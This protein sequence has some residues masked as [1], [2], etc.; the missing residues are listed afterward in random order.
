[1][2]SGARALPPSGEAHCD[3]LVVGSGA[4]GLACAVTAAHGGAKVIVAERESFIGGT[5]AW[6]GGWLYVPGYRPALAGD[7]REEIVEYLSHLAG[8]FFNRVRIEA[9]LDANQEMVEFFEGSTSVQFVHPDSAPDYHME[10]PGA[11]AGGRCIYARPVDAR[12]LGADRLRLSSY[13]REITVL[14]VMPQIGPDLQQ[15]LHANR[16]LRSFLYVAARL[17]RNWVER[18]RYR[19]GLDLSNGNALI[20]RLLMSTAH[21]GVQV[22][23]SARVDQLTLSNGV[24]DGALLKTVHG[25]VRVRATQGVVLACGG[26]SHNSELR[27]RLFAH[28]SGG[29]DHH[30]PVSPSH[31]GEALRLSAE[32]GGALDSNVSQ[33]AAW[34]P[35]T[36][37]RG[38]GRTRVFPHLRGVGLPGIIAVTRH[39]QRFTNE[40]D[41]YHDF[42]QAM[43][44]ANADEVDVHAFLVCDRTTMHR[45]GIG[46][47]KPW[48]LPRVGYRRSGY[49]K[50]GR[51]LD[52][53][54]K[55]AGIDPAPL[56]ETIEQFNIYARVGQDPVFERGKSEFNWFKGDLEHRPNPSLAP[57]ERGPFYAVKVRLGDL[58]T[59][60]GLAVDAHSQVLKNS[61]EV[62]P[63]LYAVGSAAVSVFGGAYPGHGANLGPAMTFGF[64]LGRHLGRVKANG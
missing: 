55:R 13:L 19:R 63:G 33:P 9:F 37:F 21:L 6:S 47:A 18:I 43:V 12:E 32:A 1:M 62:V 15:F 8:A 30:S 40:S 7:S 29:N 61:G 64:L 44:M 52:Q 49:L 57:L 10:A 23:T 38:R 20:A 46:F 3:I 4:A 14:G 53:L 54:A 60:A 17:V 48:P 58:G 35:V 39:G 50:V 22:M 5:S 11:K 59:F 41:S 42:G 26:F 56:R 45:Y 2:S 31:I 51:T 24:V 36:T 27:S 16:S 34:A 25:E 28:G